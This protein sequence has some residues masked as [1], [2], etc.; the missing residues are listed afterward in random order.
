MILS[1]FFENCLLA[2]VCLRMEKAILIIASKCP[3][4]YQDIL[5]MCILSKPSLASSYKACCVGSIWAEQVKLPVRRWIFLFLNI[6][7]PLLVYD[8]YRSCR[9]F[10]L[11]NAVIYGLQQLH[12]L[13][14][15]CAFFWSGE[16]P[17][18]FVLI[19]Y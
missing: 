5:W 13:H 12:K 9:S 10:S 4:S 17:V 6:L 16:S 11:E 3:T 7:L 8:R 18:K 15:L 1:S 19:L 2:I 14:W